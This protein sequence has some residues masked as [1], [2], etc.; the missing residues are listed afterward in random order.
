MNA[1]KA[2]RPGRWAAGGLVLALLAGPAMGRGAADADGGDWSA[3]ASLLYVEGGEV[4]ARIRGANPDG[5]AVARGD[6]QRIGLRLSG[7]WH[8]RARWSLEAAWVGLGDADARLGGSGATD[9]QVLEAAEDLHPQ[10]AYGI[11]L[12]LLRHWDTGTPIRL[13]AGG[14]AW[15]WRSEWSVST[16]GGSRDYHRTGTDLFATVAADVSVHESMRL[17]GRWDRYRLEAGEV[18]SFGVGL[19]YRF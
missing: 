18:D 10:T 7:A 15:T 19:L 12:G 14:G 4:P 8:W 13:A 3:S 1:G 11:A 6:D 9:D 16:V 2:E 5:V 17:R